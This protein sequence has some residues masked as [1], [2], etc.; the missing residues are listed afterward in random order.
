MVSFTPRINQL[1]LYKH[2][3]HIPII[4]SASSSSG[5]ESLALS[6]KTGGLP[7]YGRYKATTTALPPRHLTNSLLSP[8]PHEGPHGNGCPSP[9][10]RKYLW[11]RHRTK[12]GDGR[13]TTASDDKILA[14]LI[15]VTTP[16]RTANAAY[17]ALIER[18]FIQRNLDISGLSHD[19]ALQLI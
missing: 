13:L 1:R 12:S 19:S 6:R 2:S 10:R 4:A 11:N 14:G 7:A 3:R 5:L 9:H 16:K 18:G 17:L 8:Y 15:I